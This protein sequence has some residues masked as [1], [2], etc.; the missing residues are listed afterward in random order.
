MAITDKINKTVGKISQGVGLANEVGEVF[1]ID[2]PDILGLG[3]RTKRAETGFDIDRFSSVINQVGVQ[4]NNLFM[5]SLPVPKVLRGYEK[6]ADTIPFLCAGALL[7]GVQLMTD[8]IFRYGYGPYEKMPYLPQFTEFQLQFIVDSQGVILQYFQK[9]INS[10]INFDASNGF[11]ASSGTLKPYE[12]EYK[13]QYVVNPVLTTFNT[14]A[15]KV[16]EYTFRDA[17]PVGLEDLSL[18]WGNNDEL[19]IL[20]VRMQYIDYTTNLLPA[21]EVEGGGGLSIMQMIQKG[22]SI[23]QI[24]GSIRKPESIGDVINVVRNAKTVTR[25]LTGL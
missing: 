20:N 6:N 2:I 11:N 23:A 12:V 8:E 25:G 16:H 1:G 19:A 14:A 7:P 18:H 9:W 4:K 15:N 22:L 17:Y 3:G 10:I 24:V 21:P 5:V 13:D